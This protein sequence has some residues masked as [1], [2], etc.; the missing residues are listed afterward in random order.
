MVTVTWCGMAGS[1]AN[2]LAT[3]FSTNP[4]L[5]RMTASAARARPTETIAAAASARLG[6][7]GPRSV[8]GG[9]RS[10]R[11]GPRSVRGRSV[12]GGR[13]AAQARAPQA[14]AIGAA[15]VIRTRPSA[16]CPQVSSSATAAGGHQPRHGSRSA[17]SQASSTGTA[18]PRWSGV[19]SSVALAPGA[20]AS[21]I[22]TAI[23]ARAVPSRPVARPRAR[24]AASSTS[25]V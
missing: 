23:T 25:R 17:A 14:T 7:G 1:P 5:S 6:P 13:R 2:R 21:M 18:L 15:P 3:G 20:G 12:R 8:R 16:T 10:V 9:P 11:G 4:P 19:S 24:Y 22:S